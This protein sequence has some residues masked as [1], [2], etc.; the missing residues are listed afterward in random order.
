MSRY[1]FCDLPISLSESSA[2]WVNDRPDS[3]WFK[4]AK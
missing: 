4:T 1:L 3:L 2:L